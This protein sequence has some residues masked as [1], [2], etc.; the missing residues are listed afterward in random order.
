MPHHVSPVK[1]WDRTLRTGLLAGAL[2]SFGTSCNRSATKTTAPLAPI[3]LEAA[4]E[5]S[6]TLGSTLLGELQR[7]IADH[8]PAQAV[9][10]CA[11]RA[12]GIAKELS[13]G[14]YTIRRIGTRVRN[15]GQNTPTQGERAILGQLSTSAPSFQGEVDG[16]PV[17][18]QA[19]FLAAPLCLTCHGTN[20]QI[21]E[22][23][24]TQL[25][26][27]YPNDEATGYALGDLRGAFVV[28]RKPA[29]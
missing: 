29:H 24:R 20:E 27:R 4:K 15:Q 1:P 17:V 12:P 8:G 3:P 11:D 13:Q 16:R 18:M 5:L 9:A 22:A 26:E 19:I 14:A 2:L 6:A 23:V 28:E 7:A 25:A 21:P 10:V